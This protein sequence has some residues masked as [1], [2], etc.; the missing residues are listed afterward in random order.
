MNAR[1]RYGYIYVRTHPSYDAHQACKMGKTNCIPE[2]DSLYATGEVVR[3]R[4]ETV[5]QVPNQQM[6]IIER[7]LQQ[8]F[9]EF[10][11]RYDAGT[12]FYDKQIISRIEPYLVRMGFEYKGLTRQ[13]IDDL[14]RVNRLRK[15][16]QKINIRGLIQQLILRGHTNPQYTPRNYQQVTIAKSV[17]HFARYDKGLLVLTC[18]VGKT[19]ISLWITQAL[20]ATTICIGVP[21]KLLLK[22]WKNIICELFSEIPYLVVSGGVEVDGIVAFLEK[23]PQKC[24]VLTTYS[25]SHKVKDATKSASFVFGM[26]LLDECHHL[27]ASNMKLSNTTKTYVQMLQ[28]PT[29]K[30]LSL[31]ATL[32]QLETMCDKDDDILVIS[33]DNVEYFGEIIDRKSLLWAIDEKV[34]C[35]YVI[36]TMITEEEQLVRFPISEENDK[37]LF[38]SA[39]ATLKSIS[40][41]HSHHLLI[42][43][44]NKDH[45]LKIVQYITWLLEN[46]YF[47]IPGLYYSNYHSEMN[48]KDQTDIL[49]KFE[50]SN[51]GI[52]VCVYCLGEGWDFPLLDGVVFAE[53]MT[54][55]IRIVQSVLRASRKNKNDSDKKTKIIL[56]VLNRDDWIENNNNTD[57]KKVRE[58]IYQLGLE[59]ETISHKI[60]V[61][62]MNIETQKSR[63]TTTGKGNRE[64]TVDDEYDDELT[65]KIRLKT[66]KRTSLATT[67][68]AAR[69]IIADNRVKTKEDYYELCK[70]NHRL[71][72]QPETAFKGKFT[73]WIEYLGISREY[74]D[75]D[76]CRK[77]IG[78]YLLA[79]PEIKRHLEPSM[80]INDLCKKDVLFPPNGLWV[81]YYNVSDLRDI[82][83]MTPKKKK[84]SIVL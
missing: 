59:D 31:T 82:I 18:G 54:S 20:R 62:R 79:Y 69:K 33:N 60:K 71:P 19:L 40:D 41:G 38:L 6:G 30:Q 70:R 49:D 83:T 17:E 73:N 21:S 7:L 37:R 23:N 3:G 48:G 43:A 51:S 16:I 77:K 74:Y 13:E 81:E 65:E 32:K 84:A 53:N 61:F 80:I 12:E 68:E 78:E 56:P 11:V 76:T 72:D 15:T 34:V 50:K 5:F 42:Y 75:L 36:Q 22:Q 4:F 29:A 46:H 66:V 64:M 47:D 52:I 9:R 44:N 35:D 10:N 24:I 28:I 57:L 14:V 39:F 63:K 58:V 55:N 8:E 1:I 45:S 2:R 67:Y 25:S 27:T 26:K